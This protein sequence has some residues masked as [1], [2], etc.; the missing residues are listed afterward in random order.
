M[1]SSGRPQTGWETWNVSFLRKGWK[2]WGCSAWGG[3]DWGEDFIS[4]YKYL[5][6]GS[7]VDEARLFSVVPSNRTR[8][9]GQKLEH[10]EFLTN[11]RKEFFTVRVTGT[12][13]WH[14]LPREVVESPSLVIF[15]THLDTFLC[16]LLQ[17]TCC[18]RGLDS[19]VSRDL[20]QPLQFCHSVILKHQY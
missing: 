7:Q 10:R 5:K 19:V 6:C 4:V 13:H 2:T 15:K 14:R 20:F 8:G 12:E 3:D 11:M 9:N 18:S 1:E 17:E 16:D